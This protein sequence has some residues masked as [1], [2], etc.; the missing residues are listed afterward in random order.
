MSPLPARMADRW[1]ARPEPRPGQAQLYWHM[2]MRDQPQVCA[3]AALARQRLDGFPGLHFAPGQ[4]LHLSVLRLGLDSDIPSDV[5]DVLVRETRQRLQAVPPVTVTLGRVL[6]HPEAI[7][8]GVAPDRAL[9]PVAGRDSRGRPQNARNPRRSRT[10][11]LDPA[12]H[13]RLQHSGTG[14]G[15]HSRRARPRVAELP[16]H[17]RLRQPRRAARTRTRM[18]LGATRSPAFGNSARGNG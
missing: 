16:G 1:H 17:H 9:D 7:A 13:G 15:P 5:I 2:L 18:G 14:R 8:L 12:R 11:A 3:L 10:W 6:Y 4:W